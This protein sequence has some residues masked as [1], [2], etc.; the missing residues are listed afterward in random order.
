[1]RMKILVVEDEEKILDFITS[2]LEQDGYEVFQARTG[3]EA[4]DIFNQH[5]PHCM[6]LDL[7]LPDLS[8]EIVCE[9]VRRKSRVP[10]IMLTAKAA[11]RDLLE[12]FTIGADD[13]MTKPFSPKELLV[14]ITAL[15]RRTSR[16]AMPLTAVFRY[17]DGLKID[18]R[19]RIVTKN[20]TIV[21]L[22]HHE[23][24][25]LKVFASNPERTFSREELIR[26]SFGADFAGYDRTID[27]HIKNLRRKI[28]ENP[29]EPRI[30]MTV[31]GLGYRFRGAR[32]ET[33]V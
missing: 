29:R 5:D 25:L 19:N 4:L 20:G 28:E 30:I 3:R 17:A 22:T 33:P 14:R 8:G 18:T 21:K 23:Y 11:E 26:L 15:L 6:V 9:T 7:M 1:M 12:G 31:H 27:A 32:D 16:E 10:I 2:Y 13:Y 24:M